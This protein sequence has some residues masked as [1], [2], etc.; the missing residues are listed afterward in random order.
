MVDFG[1]Q[2]HHFGGSD[3]VRIMSA[4]GIS[5]SWTLDLDMAGSQWGIFVFARALRN[6]IIA[7][8]YM[9]LDPQNG[10]FWT[11]FGVDLVHFGPIREMPSG[12]FHMESECMRQGAAGVDSLPII[13]CGCPEF[14]DPG[15]WTM[16]TPKKR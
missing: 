16:G 15:I 13:P 14:P 1:P 10:R 2:N 12:P 7:R 9:I 6:T 5:A 8:E 3:L 4:H 11:I